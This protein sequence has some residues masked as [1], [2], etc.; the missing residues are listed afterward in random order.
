[1][2][3]LSGSN[4]VTRT[5]TNPSLIKGLTITEILFTIQTNNSPTKPGVISKKNTETF[6]R[7]SK[8]NGLNIN[9]LISMV[10]TDKVEGHHKVV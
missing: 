5:T 7:M 1:M 4:K 3:K 9:L 8:V 2:S 10:E 6:M